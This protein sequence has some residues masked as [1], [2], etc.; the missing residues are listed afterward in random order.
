VD[1]FET[2]QCG[3]GEPVSNCGCGLNKSHQELAEEF[4]ADT[5]LCSCGSGETIADCDCSF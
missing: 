3:S 4:F 2:C 5:E 1:E